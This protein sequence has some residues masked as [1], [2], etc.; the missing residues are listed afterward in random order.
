MSKPACMPEPARKTQ[1]PAVLMQMMTG[2]WVSQVIYTVSK[3]GIADLLKAGPRH[4][5]ELVTDLEA[6]EDFLYRVLRASGSL[7]LFEEKEGRIFQT[8]PLGELLRSDHP[9]SMRPVALMLGEEHYQAWGMLKDAVLSGQSPF[10]SVFGMQVFEYFEKN[11]AA[12]ETFNDAMTALVRNDHGIIASS[13]D[14]SPFRRIVDVG[15]GHGMLLAAILGRYPNLEGVL[16]DLPHVAK[17]AADTLAKAGLSKRC[18]IESGDFFKAVASGGDAYIL[19]HIV[20]DWSDDLAVRILQNI[21]QVIPAHGRL[22]LVETVI[23]PGNSH[24]MAKLMDLNMLVMTPG[25]RERT[26]AEY[27]SLLE[28]AGFR[29]IRIVPTPSEISIIEAVRQ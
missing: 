27:A 21:R 6:N 16:F 15:G 8:T 9:D 1:G 20:H 10:Q 23:S 28:R 24:A 3:L 11:P 14:F 22:L 29:L 25:G 17:S 7:G 5:T 4:I 26:E 19:A 13:Y 12:G 2:Y 18:Q